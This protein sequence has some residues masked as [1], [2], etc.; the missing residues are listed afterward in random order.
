MEAIKVLVISD[1]REYVSARPEAAIFLGL[2]KRGVQ[3]TIMTYGSAPWVHDFERAGIRVIPFH[4]SKKRDSHAIKVI[5]EELEGGA[6]HFLHLFNNKA[7]RNGVQA[8]KGLDVKV[9]V[10]RSYTSNIH[11]LDPSIYLKFFHPRIDKILCNSKATTELLRKNAVLVRDRTVHINK[12]HDPVWY[13]GVE[14]QDLDELK[15]PKG[16]FVISFVG[17]IRRMKGIEYLIAALK[18]LDSGL[19]INILLVGNGSEAMADR[20]PEKWKEKV[21]G[22]GFTE[23]PL[24][25]IAASD[26]FI[27]PSIKGEAITKS[28]VEAMSLG[29]PVICSDIA[30]NAEIAIHGRT[31]YTFAIKDPKAIATAILEVYQNP[32]MRSRIA[33]EAKKYIAEH[34]HTDQ[35][36][37]HYYA[38]YKQVL[39]DG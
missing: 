34:L 19:P 30:G 17:N 33:A 22:L 23:S 5:R 24:E 31:A 35:T 28:L 2:Q 25:I 38:L 10:Y 36:V 18:Y 39:K 26:A 27:L 14:P 9:L 8:A 7:I 12:G 3:V 11:W 29:V 16:R 15:I 13:A 1:Y 20:A 37:G 6:Y 21:L 32:Q 4:P